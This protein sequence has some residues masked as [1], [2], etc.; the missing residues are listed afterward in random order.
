M[1][2]VNAIWLYPAFCAGFVCGILFCVALTR[3]IDKLA[4]EV[5]R[6]KGD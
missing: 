2:E 6:G 3:W 1:D 4:K 5:M